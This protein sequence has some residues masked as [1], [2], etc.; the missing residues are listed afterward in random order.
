MKFTRFCV[1]TLLVW[2]ANAFWKF[3]LVIMKRAPS[4]YAVTSLLSTVVG[5]IP[6]RYKILCLVERVSYPSNTKGVSDHTSKWLCLAG[7]GFTIEVGK[8]FNAT[9]IGAKISTS[10]YSI[11]RLVADSYFVVQCML[12]S[13]RCILFCCCMRKSPKCDPHYVFLSLGVLYE[14]CICLL[15]IFIVWE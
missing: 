10:R 11:R 4:I 13:W 3:W 7:R 2:T 12:G 9:L 8:L 14:K 15:N 1:H 5:L 6:V